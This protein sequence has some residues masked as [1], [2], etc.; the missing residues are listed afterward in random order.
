M[1]TLEMLSNKKYINL[2]TVRKNG[3]PVKTPV[4][5]V[6]SENLVYVVT[7]EN[8]GKVKRIKNDPKVRIAPCNFKGKPEGDWISGTAEFIQGENFQK[9]V[10]LRNKKYGLMAKLAGFLSSSKG[11]LVVFSIKLDNS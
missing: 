5:F 8:T 2:E 10:N 6:I 1:T 4:W 7:R 3:D 9:A 11:N